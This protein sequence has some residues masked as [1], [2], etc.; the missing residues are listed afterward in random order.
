[1]KYPSEKML[2]LNITGQQGDVMKESCEYALKIAYNLLTGE[3]KNT[4]LENSKNKK[5]FGIHIHTPEAATKKD[6]PSAGA[7]MTL[8]FYSVLTNRKVN[9]KVALTGEIDLWKNVTAIGGV[10]AKLSG[11]KKAGVELALIPK[12]NM[13]DLEIIRNE[14]NS[15]EDDTFEVKFIDNIRDV[16]EYC[17]I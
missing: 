11:A 7:A 2:E 6:G 10:Y 12:D 15:P 16:L 9:N 14:N 5:N 8:A 13:D 1:M 4:I 17:L 3:E